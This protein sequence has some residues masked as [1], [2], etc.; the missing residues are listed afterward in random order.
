MTDQDDVYTIS[1]ENSEKQETLN[2]L[3]VNK[4]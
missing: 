3:L 2:K 4:L 1:N